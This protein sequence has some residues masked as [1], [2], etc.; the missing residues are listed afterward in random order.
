MMLFH[1][2]NILNVFPSTI[3]GL[4]GRTFGRTTTKSRRKL[5]A[6]NESTSSLQLN[7]TQQR[8][9]DSVRG[10]ELDLGK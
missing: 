7:T 3:S 8:Y 9:L 2:I 4:A 5:L 1:C 6:K 10:N